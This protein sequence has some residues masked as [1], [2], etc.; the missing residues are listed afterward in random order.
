MAAPFHLNGRLVDAEEVGRT[1]AFLC[2]AA[3]S[4]I[5][6]TDVAVDGGYTAIGPEQQTDQVSVLGE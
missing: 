2:S 3:A 4:G 5:N 1:V 6:G